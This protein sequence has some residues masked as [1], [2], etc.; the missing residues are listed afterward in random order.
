MIAHRPIGYYTV[1]IRFFIQALD[2]GKS[3]FI[4]AVYATAL[5]A[6]VIAEEKHLAFLYLIGIEI[7]ES[8]VECAKENAK[9]NDPY[10]LA[11]DADN[12]AVIRSGDV[13]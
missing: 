9:E 10:K 3:L 6:T 12:T 1:Y 4:S 8:A 7:V 5:I 2:T 13:N 11:F